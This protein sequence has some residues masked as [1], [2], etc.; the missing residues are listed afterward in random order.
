M[1]DIS[2]RNFM[3]MAGVALTGV[4]LTGITGLVSGCGEQQAST[5]QAKAQESKSGSAKTVA[6]TGDKSAVYFTK[7]IDA[8]HLIK[9]YE[10]V[11]SG[12]RGKVSVKLHTGEPHGP[13][14]LPRAW[15]RH[16]KHKFP[17]QQ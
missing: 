17:I 8:E 4:G 9:L 10:K 11:N 5:T 3:K 1:S 12:I 16:F 2:G 15:Y 6:E 7:H 13:N 14:I